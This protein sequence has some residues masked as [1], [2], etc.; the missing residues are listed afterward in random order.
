M[1]QQGEMKGSLSLGLQTVQLIPCYCGPVK[2]KGEKGELCKPNEWKPPHDITLWQEIRYITHKNSIVSD[3]YEWWGHI[4]SLRAIGYIAQHAYKWATYISY[5]VISY[6]VMSV[7][8][9][10]G[11]LSYRIMSYHVCPT[12]VGTH[13]ISYHVISCLSHTCRDSYPIVFPWLTV[14]RN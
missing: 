11:L 3:A 14:G 4:I 5:H 7:P 9:W 8:H 12:L 1:A 2:T 13:I 10:P 6:H